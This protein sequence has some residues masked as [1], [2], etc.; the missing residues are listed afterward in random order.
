[1][2][3]GLCMYFEEFKIGQHF[4]LNPIVFTAEEINQ[5]AQKFDPQPIH[6]D[7]DFAQKTMFEGII[8]S[9]YH[10]LSSIWGEWIRT[11][12][13]GYEIIAGSGMDFVTWNAPVRAG[14][15]IDTDVEVIETNLSKKGTRGQVVLRFTAKN[16]EN[17]TVLVTQGRAYLKAQP[18]A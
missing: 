5:F 13:F 9:G 14:D 17:I 2:E 8:A 3:E 7:E 6:I 4:T 10:T 18:R 11:E 15:I 1:M 12:K 16:Q